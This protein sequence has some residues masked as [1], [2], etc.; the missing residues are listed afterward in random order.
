[1]KINVFMWL[2]FQDRLPTGVVLKKHN[3]KGDGC[4]IICKILESADHILFCCPLAK[5][6]WA[7][8]REALQWGRT[9]SSM[10]DFLE[11]WLPL[12]CRNYKAK[13][14][15]FARV[16][17]TLKTVRNKMAIKGVF[18]QAPSSIIFKF[19]SFIQRW[20]QL[21]RASDRATLDGWRAQVK[22]WMEA[23]L[24]KIRDRPPAYFFL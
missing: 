3:W 2:A 20:R 4:C 19:D 11:S 7:C 1:M 8:A 9:P 10:Q 6:A 15:L 13:M 17:W 16:L 18:V 14:M 5:F 22:G 12:G 21:L 24:E 23:F